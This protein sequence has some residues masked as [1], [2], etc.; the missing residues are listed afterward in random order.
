ASD[1]D[2]AAEQDSAFV[3]P[4]AERVH[5]KPLSLKIV[6]TICLCFSW[7]CLGLFSEILGPCLIRIKENTN[8]TYLQLGE[9][10]SIRAFGYFSGSV[11]GG[12][13]AD[14]F[15]YFQ[16]IWM[17]LSLIVA[18][19]VNMI[20]P[21]CR[22]IVSVSIIFY[23]AGICHGCLT[24]SGNPLLGATWLEKSSGPFNLMHAGYGVGA[25]IAPLIVSAF[26]PLVNVSLPNATYAMQKDARYASILEP[27]AI[28][29]GANLLCA[30]AFLCLQFHKRYPKSFGILL[31][32]SANHTRH[33]KSIPSEQSIDE[34][35]L[36]RN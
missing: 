18:G 33:K 26:T 13:L 31:W 4:D 25:S 11:F 7:M 24:T 35:K 5:G 15:A 19:S 12:Y 21:S 23:A 32:L 22:S 29:L 6:I 17:V 34:A 10:L 1:L 30:V 16:Y 9:A 27:F 28:S 8:A 36:E 14:R 2:T 3:P 20:I